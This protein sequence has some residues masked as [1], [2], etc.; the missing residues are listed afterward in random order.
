MFNVIIIPLLTV[1][2]AVST[3]H[4][5]TLNSDTECREY[6]EVYY[7]KLDDY[8]LSKISLRKLDTDS[9]L[10]CSLSSRPKESSAEGTKHYIIQS[11]DFMKQGPWNTEIYVIGN[12]AKPIK[13]KITFVDHGNGGVRAKWLNEKLLFIQGWWGRIVS[14]D[15]ILDVD[16]SKWV[17]SQNANYGNL[18]MP[19]DENMKNR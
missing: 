12:R 8:V 13:L 5:A 9:K 4:S 18:I 14:T 6:D 16:T 7:E 3:S 1:I 11:P 17:Y 15:L 2:F 19:C 10:P